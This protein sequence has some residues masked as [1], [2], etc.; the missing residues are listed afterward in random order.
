MAN[1]LNNRGMLGIVIMVIILS[2]I[3]SAATSYMMII[4]TESKSVSSIDYTDRA[5]DAAFSGVQYGMAISQLKKAL[6]A[7][8]QLKER[9]YMVEY[10]GANCLDDIWGQISDTD[11]THYPNLLVS[12]WIYL[13]HDFAALNDD[14]NPTHKPYFFKLAIYPKNISGAIATYSYYI[15]S[16]AKYL[17]YNQD[18]SVKRDYKFQMLALIKIDIKKRRQ[19]LLKWKRQNWQGTGATFFVHDEF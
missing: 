8:A 9:V 10:V 16:Q 19:R 1:K 12:N 14:N 13:N 5:M 4:Q 3:M 7:P 15:K 6:F 17:L 18:W 2:L 11:D